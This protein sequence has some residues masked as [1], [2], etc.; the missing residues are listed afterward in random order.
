MSALNALKLV[1]SKPQ[2]GLSPVVIRRNKLSSKLSEQ[3]ALATAKREGKTYAPTKLKAYKDKETGER[4]TM[5]VVKRV[6]EWW[7]VTEAG[8]VNLVLKYGSKQIALDPKGT[9]NAIEV[10]SADELV[11][12]LQ[13]LKAAVEGGELDAQIETAAAAVRK[14]FRK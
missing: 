14:G 13:T 1:V 8:K 12:A 2:R 9:K 5:E 4:K 6:R 3:I 11:G 7:L 10:G